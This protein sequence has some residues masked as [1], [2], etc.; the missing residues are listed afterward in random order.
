METKLSENEIKDIAKEVAII[1]ATK[2]GY[3]VISSEFE[4]R[5]KKQAHSLLDSSFIYTETKFDA[6]HLIE[7]AMSSLL[8]NNGYFDSTVYRCVSEY[9]STEK[10]K[11]ASIRHL[12]SRIKEIEAELEKEYEEEYE[13]D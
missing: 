2:Q 10:F 8:K 4:A 5:L 12:K 13:E 7:L 11:K 9:F 1:M 6:A 3:D